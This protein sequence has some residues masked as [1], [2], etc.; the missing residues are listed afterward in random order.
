MP[1]TTDDKTANGNIEK[2]IEYLKYCHSNIQ[3]LKSSIYQRA[4]ILVA[5][6]AFIVTGF[7]CFVV[8]FFKKDYFE[9]GSFVVQHN[10]LVGVHILFLILS[11]L[12]LIFF[13]LT[14]F[15]AI[16]CL[17]PF[18]YSKIRSE[19]NSIKYK[20][21]ADIDQELYIK[22]FLNKKMTFTTFEYICELDE[23]KFVK[24]ARELDD[25]KILEQLLSSVFYGAH[26]SKSRYEYLRKAYMVLWLDMFIFAAMI[27]TGI[28]L[29]IL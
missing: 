10:L 9:D 19:N 13:L 5:A 17:F 26:I 14:A 4:A 18:N 12:F 22:D 3:D 24:I 23:P 8:E 16:K 11:I 25:K 27:L 6:I 1:E 21:L 15:L 20:E 2:K 29:K 7:S 28:I